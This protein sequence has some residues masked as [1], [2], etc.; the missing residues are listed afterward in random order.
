M[1]MMWLYWS[2]K[3]Y[4]EPVISPE[5]FRDERSG[6]Q[7]WAPIPAIL[8]SS[9]ALLCTCQARDF[10]RRALYLPSSGLPTPCSVPGKAVL[11][12]T[13]RTM[14][15]HS[16]EMKLYPWYH[17][18]RCSYRRYELMDQMFTWVL[19]IKPAL[20][21]DNLV[22]FSMEYCQDIHYLNRTKHDYHL[23][24]RDVNIINMSKFRLPG[25]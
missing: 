19:S 5:Y 18:N 16:R 25:R 12:R 8:W 11:R 14:S 22:P 20:L 1:V 9:S 23:S 24:N 6:L 4:P 13:L 10:Q 21:Q 2:W 17:Y 15:R 3:P 7:R